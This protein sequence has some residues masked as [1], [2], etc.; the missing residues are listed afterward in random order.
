[1]LLPLLESCQKTQRSKKTH[2]DISRGNLGKARD[3]LHGLISTYPNDLKLRALFAEVYS[4]LQFPQMAGRYW[5]LQ[6][7]KTDAMEAA[8]AEFESS[9]GNDPLQMLCA[10][11]FRGNVG[12]L[13]SEFARQTLLALRKLCKRKY[14]RYPEFGL[15]GGERWQPGLRGRV[16]DRV[17]LV[18]CATILLIIL[19]LAII[20]FER[21]I[22]WIR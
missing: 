10:L 7:K 18:G 1:M 4:R 15:K 21:V 8:C 19:T 13:E 22:K 14:D 16:T 11:K 12:E 17:M 9:C 2:E 20:G 3:R 6:E 5:Y